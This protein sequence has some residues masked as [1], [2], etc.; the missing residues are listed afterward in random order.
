MGVLCLNRGGAKSPPVPPLSELYFMPMMWFCL[1]ATAFSIN[2]S[3]SEASEGHGSQLEK[4][5]YLQLRES[6][7]ELKKRFSNTKFN[8]LKR[9]DRTRNL[10]GVWNQLQQMEVYQEKLQGLRK[11]VHRVMA[12]Q[13]SE[14]K[15]TCVA[16]QVEDAVNELQRQMGQLERNIC[17]HQK[18][19]DMTCRL[20]Q[21]MDEYQLWCEEASATIA[22]VR[23][24]SL[25][26]RSTE[27][28]SVLYRQFEKFVWPTVPQ[29]EERISQITELAVR[30]H[31]VEEGQRY[32]QKTVSKH[33]EMVESIR[34]LSNGLMELEAKLKLESLKQQQ[35]DEDKEVEE[36]GEREHRRQTEEQE[37][38]KEKRRMKQ[39]KQRDNRSTQ[40]AADM[41]E[42]KETGHTPELITVNDRKEAAAA[43]REPP[44]EKTQSHGVNGPKAGRELQSGKFTSSF[45]STHTLTEPQ[46]TPSQSIIGPSFPDNKKE[47]HS[48]MEGT[49]L[50]MDSSFCRSNT[51]LLKETS[52]HME[53]HQPE[54]MT[55]DFFSN[56][57]YDCAS[58]DDISL[59]PLAETPESNMF[60]S[61][62]E[63][64]FCFS[65]HSVHISQGSHQFHA[66]S[67]PT[68]TGP[69][70]Q[71]KESGQTESCPASTVSLHSRTRFRSESRSFM[72]SPPTVPVTTL[73]TSTLSTILKIKDSSTVLSLDNSV[74]GNNTIDCSKDRNGLKKRSP[75]KTPT[76]DLSQSLRPQ[77][78][79]GSDTV[80]HNYNSPKG[81]TGVHTFSPSYTK[82][83]CILPEKRDLPEVYHGTRSHTHQDLKPVKNSKETTPQR[84]SFTKASTSLISQ[85]SIHIQSSFSGNRCTIQKVCSNSAQEGTINSHSDPV[86]KSEQSFQSSSVA[87]SVPHKDLSLLQDDDFL[88]ISTTIPQS[89]TTPQDPDPS[90]NST[91]TRSKQDQD[92]PS[93][94]RDSSLWATTTI[95]QQSIF[96]Q[97]FSSG[98]SQ[99][100]T[101]SNNDARD[102]PVNLTH[103]PPQPTSVNNIGI[104]CSKQSLQTVYPLQEFLIFNHTLQFEHGP[105]V[106]PSLAQPAP[107]H[108]EPQS[109]TSPH[110][111]NL[112]GTYPYSPPH[113]L[114]PTQD[115]DICLPMAIREE[116][117]LTPQIQGP[118]LLPAHLLQPSSESLPLEKASEPGLPCFTRPLSQ[119][120]IMVGSPV[121]LEVEV[122]GKPEPRLTR[123]SSCRVTH[124][125]VS[126]CYTDQNRDQE[127]TC[128][129]LDS[130]R[131]AGS[132]SSV[133]DNW[134]VLEA[135]DIIMEDWSTWFGTLCVLLW[136]L[137]LILL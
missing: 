44:L 127:Q 134:L 16:R 70:P 107:P 73:F 136:L 28:V 46:A 34:E 81:D 86:P 53:L 83:D 100:D 123:G 114:T 126:P 18:T 120:I 124:E 137:C 27:A 101:T 42:L 88:E 128:S 80:L 31:G 11:R 58:P 30:L 96:N 97:S 79:N 103:S 41:H 45:T 60:L 9:N 6:F 106:S 132:S 71:Q 67:E 87:D 54:V 133:G 69:L 85:Q 65:S 14:V 98:R 72:P 39:K 125:G 3:G 55:E 118:P 7:K 90:Q 50:Q 95:T 94:L 35:F 121:T 131:L 40:E 110:P 1:Q 24:F 8:Y 105:S 43:N 62:V 5:G 89:S 4:C 93:P 129:L 76:Q 82:T 91:N 116:I 109:H 74:H 57:D 10:K 2:Y 48:E 20:Q 102:P 15:N 99:T 13:G 61:D 26:C 19:L 112:H 37:K 135:F 77:S 17:E 130:Q 22:R 104:C 33:S 25:E 92:V 59:P 78:F 12:Q 75:S 119:A 117:R 36:E 66:Q 68:G 113:V 47:F 63:E 49:E 21:A 52:P 29:Q 23:K 32:I 64:G 56:D 108:P 84:D 51:N 115:P 111:A 122:M 38:I